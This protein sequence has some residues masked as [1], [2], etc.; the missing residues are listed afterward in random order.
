MMNLYLIRE[1]KE[2]LEKIDSGELYPNF[3]AIYWKSVAEQLARTVIVS[4]EHDLKELRQLLEN[5][6]DQ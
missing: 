6:N 1:A 4:A 2:V 3:P 5:D